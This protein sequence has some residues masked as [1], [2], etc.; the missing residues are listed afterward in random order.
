MGSPTWNRQIPY[1]QQNI[2]GPS[3]VIDLYPTEKSNH[4]YNMKLCKD[5]LKPISSID[6]FFVSYTPLEQKFICQT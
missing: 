2:D 3:H 6:P 5:S 1:E 4:Y